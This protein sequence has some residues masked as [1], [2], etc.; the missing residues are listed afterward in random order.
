MPGFLGPAVGN[1]LIK[2]AFELLMAVLAAISAPLLSSLHDKVWPFSSSPRP[3]R[4]VLIKPF[5]A[6]PFHPKLAAM[7]RAQR[8]LICTLLDAIAAPATKD[9]DFARAIKVMGRCQ[10]SR[11]AHLSLRQSQ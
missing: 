9:D 5:P 4:Q 1:V 6:A 8:A 10:V 7:L 11:L 3:R 2:A